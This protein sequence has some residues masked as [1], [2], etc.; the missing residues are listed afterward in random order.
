LEHQKKDVIDKDCANLNSEFVY[1]INSNNEFS[2]KHMAIVV[3]KNIR[4]STIT[5]VP[6]TEAKIEDEN[7]ISR[8][9]LKQKDYKYFLYKDTSILIDN[10]ITIEKK[11]RVKRIVLK[12]IPKP[13]RRKIQKAMFET[14]K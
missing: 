10:I 7:K 4:N 2:Y 3:S 12:W 1:G 5:V 11:T 14:F 8:I 9:V 13:L 6:L